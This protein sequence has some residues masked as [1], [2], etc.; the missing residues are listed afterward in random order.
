TCAY[1][2]IYIKKR[3]ETKVDDYYIRG[4]CYWSH[5]NDNTTQQLLPF[6]DN[7]VSAINNGASKSYVYYYAQGQAGFSA[8]MPANE[9][10]LLLGAPGVYNWDGTSILYED[11]EESTPV[12]SRLK[13]NKRH[14]SANEFASKNIANTIKTTQTL[15]YDLLGIYITILSKLKHLKNQEISEDACSGGRECE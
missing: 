14:A 15:A 10:Q 6:I 4:S 2:W 13:I 9:K 3:S 8:H 5:I 11:V 1:R 12:A 7:D